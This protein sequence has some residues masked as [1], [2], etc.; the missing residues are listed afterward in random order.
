MEL[1]S[2]PKIEPHETASDHGF[3]FDAHNHDRNQLITRYRGTSVVGRESGHIITG[4]QKSIY[5]FGGLNRE[6]P[7]VVT[8]RLDKT[9]TIQNISIDEHSTGSQGKRCDFKCLET[10]CSEK[11]IG[12]GIAETG[13]MIKSAHDVKCLHLFEIL[14]ACMSFYSYLTSCELQEG[15]EQEYIAIRPDRSGLT[16]Y[17][18]HDILGK[19]DHTHIRLDHRALPKLD[20]NGLAVFLDADISVQ[21]NDEEAIKTEL[22]AADFES[23]YTQLNRLFSKCHHLEKSWFG[24]KGRARFFNTPSMVGLFLLTISHSGMKGRASRALKIEKVL[25]YLQ[26]G[27]GRDPCKGFGG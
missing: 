7:V 5:H 1:S 14:S 11:L 13:R 20:E 6:V 16:A 25:H 23:V 9:G 12:T 2:L 18:I 27:Y 22:L 26:T 19:R 24:L 21:Y 4:W 8:I 10:L 15:L 17:T 3:V